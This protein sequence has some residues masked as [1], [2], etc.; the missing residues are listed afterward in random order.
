M[1]ILFVM[2]F[3]TST[4]ICDCFFFHPDLTVRYVFALLFSIHKN[5]F[6]FFSVSFCVFILSGNSIMFGDDAIDGCITSHSNTD[7][8]NVYQENIL[9]SSL[10]HQ[11]IA[12]EHFII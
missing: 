9:F 10:L 2:K 3:S 1:W 4:Y 8:E 5:R 11:T 7:I 6:F 12:T